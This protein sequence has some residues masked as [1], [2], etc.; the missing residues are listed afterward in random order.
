MAKG[1]ESAD[2]QS[3]LH[4]TKGSSGSGGQGTPSGGGETATLHD[5]L[6][7]LPGKGGTKHG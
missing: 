7:L 4:A 2:M 1:K 6:G 5:P 3:P